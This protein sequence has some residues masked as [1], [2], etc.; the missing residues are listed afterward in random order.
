MS[1]NRKSSGDDIQGRRFVTVFH[2]AALGCFRYGRRQSPGCPR[3]RDALLPPS[4]LGAAAAD[5]P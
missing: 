4:H 3:D 5:G 1:R 2:E